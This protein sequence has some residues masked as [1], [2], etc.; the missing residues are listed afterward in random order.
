MNSTVA[1]RRNGLANTYPALKRALKRRAKLTAPLRGGSR[2][3]N[4]C[5]AEHLKLNSEEVPTHENYRKAQFENEQIRVTRLI[6]APRKS[7]DVTVNSPQPALFVILSDGRLLSKS[8]VKKTTFEPGQTVWTADGR[9]ERLE[10]LSDAPM[11]LLQFDFR[12]APVKPKGK[13]KTEG[14]WK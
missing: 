10:N 13:L 9:Q 2:S 11:E 4:G 14:R 8:A 3:G 12:T 1:T 6:C 5:K 7:L